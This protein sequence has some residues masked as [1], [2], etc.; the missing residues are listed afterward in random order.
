VPDPITIITPVGRLWALWL[1]AT[2]P[3]ADRGR[4]IKGPLLDL[5]FIHV[6][7]WGLARP[8][9]GTTYVLFQSNYDGPAQEYA[10]AFA[11]KVPWRIRG[12][13][14]GARGFPGPHPVTRFVDYVLEKAQTAPYHYYAAYPAGTVRTVGAALELGA[15]FRSFERRAADLTPDQLL[16]AWH[17][18]LTVEQRNL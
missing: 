2:W 17:E 10:A 9:G 18:F 14:T 1:R 13:W 7:H 11:I 5:R 8:S 4:W 15:H 6:A 3:G 12:L 16:A